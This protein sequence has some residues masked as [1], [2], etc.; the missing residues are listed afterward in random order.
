MNKKKKNW[1]M[2]IILDGEMII[3]SI[4]CP[5]HLNHIVSICMVGCRYG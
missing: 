1:K 5:L 2:P 3:D 4:A